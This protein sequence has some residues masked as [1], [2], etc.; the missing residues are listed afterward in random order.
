MLEI[1]SAYVASG[2]K[3]HVLL[4]ASSLDSIIN[5]RGTYYS[6]ATGDA[7]VAGIVS[8]VEEGAGTLGSHSTSHGSRHE[9]I[10]FQN[11]SPLLLQ[12]TTQGKDYSQDYVTFYSESLCKEIA[13]NAKADVARVVDGALKKANLSRQEIDFL[14]THQP[15][16]W[17]A[18]AW[19]EALG[20]NQER[21]HETFEKY[22]NIACCSAPINLLEAL[23]LQKL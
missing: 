22:G 10:I 4:I 8:R 21:F 15:V 11:R 5:D 2:V 23:E 12:K 14:V 6:V 18:H 16:A 9:A 3:K 20:V 1:A 7:A 19:R 13:R 17:A